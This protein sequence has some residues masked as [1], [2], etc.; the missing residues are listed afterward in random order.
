MSDNTVAPMIGNETPL[1]LT[2]RQVASLLQVSERTVSA[3]VK[4]GRLR[5]VRLS[6]VTTRTVVRRGKPV[7]VSSGGTVRFHREDVQAL[8]EAAKSAVK[9]G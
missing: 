8:I 9:T 3:L 1:L 4:S 2:Y 5:A 6:Q 7:E